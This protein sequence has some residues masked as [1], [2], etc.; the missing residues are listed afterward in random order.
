MRLNRPMIWHVLSS[1]LYSSQLG[2]LLLNFFV[3][4]NQSRALDRCVPIQHDAHLHVSSYDQRKYGRGWDFCC[5][6]RIHGYWQIRV[7]RVSLAYFS[8]IYSPILMK[9]MIFPNNPFISKSERYET[10][11]C[12]SFVRKF[13]G[14]LVSNGISA[15]IYSLRNSEMNLLKKI[16]HLLR[17]RFSCWSWI[18]LRNALTLQ[19]WILF[20]Q[21]F[22]DSLMNSSKLNYPKTQTTC[23]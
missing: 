20:L 16:Q 23:F 9:N 19:F 7:L 2:L 4:R 21:Y 6:Q 22:I 12:S 13:T 18:Q 14:L 5:P 1:P 11:T 8:L 10:L 3:G 17:P 15:D